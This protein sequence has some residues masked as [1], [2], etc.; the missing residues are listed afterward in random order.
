MR[1][2]WIT[3][4]IHLACAL[5]YFAGGSYL[6]IMLS[7]GIG[8]T[9][10]Y[11]SIW[12]VVHA[13]NACTTLQFSFPTTSAQCES[14]A[15]EFSCRSKAGFRNHI[16]CIDGMLVWTENP[17]KKQC[18][19]VGVDNRKF[20]CG[21]KG[22]FGLNLQAVCDARHRFTYIS[23]QHPASASDYLAFVTSSLY[24]QLT[25]GEGIPQGYCLY[26]DNAYVNESYM[27][28]PFQAM[29][30]GPK[31]SYNFYHS[32]VRINIECSFGILTNRWHLL[33]TPLSSK[34]S[35]SRINALISCLCKLHNFCI[36][37]GN[38]RPPERYSHDPL[39]LMDFMDSD[40]SDESEIPCPI[41]LLGG[42]EHFADVS[43]GCR[44]QIRLS[45]CRRHNNNNAHWEFPRNS[46]LHHI[47]EMDIHHPCPF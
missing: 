33:K 46:M 15:S 9:D 20:Y 35:I 43:G 24:R 44:E 40:E 30:N 8:K 31:D 32:Q 41:G 34:I 26:G 5:R 13:T 17:S 22:K 28:V 38:A 45:H 29:T 36:D 19:E 39:T 37:N 3:T 2:G 47:T 12:A 18:M 21:R 14:I 1:N 27:A 25:E 11:R 42:G 4:E 6:D 7:H 10:L 16:G 23:L